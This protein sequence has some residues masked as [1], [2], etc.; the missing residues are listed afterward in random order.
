LV[1]T[2]DGRKESREVDQTKKRTVSPSP[3]KKQKK[4]TVLDRIVRS[5]R[6]ALFA[7]TTQKDEHV[8]VV[9]I[10]TKES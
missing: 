4:E 2:A 1:R 8:V 5:I 9:D 3:A 10:I 6:F 7:S